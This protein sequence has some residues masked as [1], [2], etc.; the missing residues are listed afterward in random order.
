MVHQPGIKGQ[1]GQ[2]GHLHHSGRDF[3]LGE[4]AQGTEA[5]LLYTGKRALFTLLHVVDGRVKH[6]G[7]LETGN[8]KIESNFK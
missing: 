2:R 7:K 5:A 3:P 8:W 6:G 1:H 4:S